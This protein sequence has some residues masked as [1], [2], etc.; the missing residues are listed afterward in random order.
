MTAMTNRERFEAF[1]N[2]HPEV[3]DELRALCRRWLER[4]R[5]RWSI[6]SA[7][8]VLRWERRLAGLPAPDELYKL[9]NNYTGYYARKLMEED[10][11]LEGIFELRR[12]KDEAA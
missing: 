3:F 6:W 7:F 5:A 2:E 10:P 4:G 9:N 1:H 8:A 11:S 12:M